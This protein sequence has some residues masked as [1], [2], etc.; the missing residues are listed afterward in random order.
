MPYD[1][2]TLH[3]PDA[4]TGLTCA[5]AARRLGSARLPSRICAGNG[6][7]TTPLRLL[8]LHEVTPPTSHGDWVHLTKPPFL[9]ASAQQYYSAVGLRS[10]RASAPPNLPK[11]KRA[12]LHLAPRPSSKSAA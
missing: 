3:Y 4:G 5:M 10:A 1:G 6:L 2:D 9:S 8:R 12:S 7:T 11:R